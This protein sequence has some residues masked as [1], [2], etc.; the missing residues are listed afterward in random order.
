M[1]LDSWE[2]EILSFGVPPIAAA[3]S[4]P[5]MVISLKIPL[6]EQIFLAFS[7]GGTLLV[8]PKVSNAV[9]SL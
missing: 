4:A 2:E 6:S 5:S 1:V 8:A 9:S 7:V 3:I